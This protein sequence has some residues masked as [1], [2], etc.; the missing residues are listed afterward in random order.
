MR[1][2]RTMRVGAAVLALSLLITACAS[3]EEQNAPE[4][5]LLEDRE[6]EPRSTSTG[7][8]QD[9]PK[10]IQTENPTEGTGAGGYVWDGS[11]D[12]GITADSILIGTSGPLS[13]PAS[14]FNPIGIGVGVCAD[15][16][17]GEFGG[18]TML[19]GVTRHIEVEILDDGYSPEITAQNIRYLHEE[20]GV[21]A[22]VNV[23]G[24][25]ANTAIL[26]IVEQNEVPNVLVASGASR[27]G[28]DF[29]SGEYAY[30]VGWQPSYHTEG[31]IYAAFI[32]ANFPGATVAILQQNDE[33]G[34]DYVYG[35]ELGVEGT[36]I[37]IVTVATYNSGDPDVTQ[38]MISLAD[39]GADVFFSVT[40]P[41]YAAQAMLAIGALDW[42]PIQFLVSPS[43]SAS[44]VLVPA[45]DA[46]GAV[47][48]IYSAKWQADPTDPSLADDPA[49][50][51]YREM[52]NKYSNLNTDDA[53]S[54]FAWNSCLAQ[55]QIF[56]NIYPTR[57]S[58]L[59]T[60]GNLDEINID[61]PLVYTT[62]ISTNINF[63]DGWPLE[64]MQ[65]EQY[66]GGKWE[67][68]GVVIDVDQ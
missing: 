37:E 61:V 32:A 63:G 60:M 18:V 19:D 64:A 23:V 16:L 53:F 52:W 41:K 45:G 25:P 48:G 62:N 58:L 33:F 39:T 55:K 7:G 46:G 35:F 24:S 13:G 34:D 29:V 57:D 59:S 31:K 44:S 66:N 21:F 2:H 51:E 47:E 27:W 9:E 1:P 54:L 68:V 65:I 12:T 36:G 15:Y 42:D 56:S 20:V 38:Q 3:N 22:T 11:M 28:R 5:I 49:M 43:N 67:K 14:T 6:D 4:P 17:N 26:D 30:T 8:A 50:M 40:T 10:S